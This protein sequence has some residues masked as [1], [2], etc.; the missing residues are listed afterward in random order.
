MYSQRKFTPWL[1]E[2]DIDWIVCIPETILPLVLLAIS[3]T[4]S[5]SVDFPNTKDAGEKKNSCSFYFPSHKKIKEVLFK[6]LL[7]ICCQSSDNLNQE[8]GSS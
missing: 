6:P 2:S 8:Y 1:M 3:L 5:T 7:E 4:S